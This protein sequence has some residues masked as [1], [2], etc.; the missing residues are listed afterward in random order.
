VS[1]LVASRGVIDP[2]LAALPFADQMFVYCDNITVTAKSETDAEDIL[3]A[4]RSAL[5]SSPAGPLH[6]NAEIQHISEFVDFCRYRLKRWH[7]GEVRI[8]PSRKAFLQREGQIKRTYRE[9]IPQE[10]ETNARAYNREWVRQFPAWDHCAAGD[11]LLEDTL[12]IAMQD[13]RDEMK[14]S[15]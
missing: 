7:G 10:A 2:A 15:K 1:S 4:L 6:L 3:H 14:S 8:V 5:L 12:K 13:A 9:S 11:E